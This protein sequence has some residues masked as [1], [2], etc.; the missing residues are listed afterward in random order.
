MEQG[1]LQLTLAWD[2]KEIVSAEIVS[3]RPMLAGA[4]RGLPV[5]RVSEIIPRVF[6]LCRNAQD[7][8]A[9]LCVQAARGERAAVDDAR[10]PTLAVAIEA[11]VEHLYHL[12][13]VWPPL[14]QKPYRANRIQEFGAWRKRLQAVVDAAAAAALGV[15]LSNWLNELEAPPFADRVAAAAVALLPQLSAAEWAA[16]I[17]HEDFATQPTF[18]GQAVET[19]VLAR[20]AGEPGV[21]LLLAGGQRVQARLAARLLELRWLTAGLVEPSRLSALV[22]ATAIAVGCGLAR[23]ETARGT[24]LHRIEIAADCVERYRII[25]PTEWNFHPQGAFVREMSGCP[26]QTR[27]DARIRATCLALSLD[28]CVPFEIRIVDA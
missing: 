4:L 22:D 13:M 19:G 23:V 6:S 7:A 25:A 14:L 15:D 8:A 20:H 28:P 24:L 27:D 26:A 5:A 12:L 9:R 21:A 16:L 3:T 2:G 10:D 1:V 17:D 11:I 18:A